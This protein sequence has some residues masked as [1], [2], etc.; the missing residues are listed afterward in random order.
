MG[1]ITVVKTY[2]LPELIYPFTVLLD[3]PPPPPQKKRS[4]TKTKFRKLLSFILD[5][6]PDKL[7]ELPYIESIKMEVLEW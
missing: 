5:S 7:S 2:A 3:P 6:K 4:N 1:K